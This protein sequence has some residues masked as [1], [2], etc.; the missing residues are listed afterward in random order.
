MLTWRLMGL[1]RRHISGDFVL[2]IINGDLDN[3]GDQRSDEA[4]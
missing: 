4:D 3:V 2:M 1:Q